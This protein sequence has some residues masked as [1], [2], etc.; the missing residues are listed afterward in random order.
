[1]ENDQEFGRLIRDLRFKAGL[2]L[3]ALADLVGVD[4]SYL[5]KIENGMLPP[6]SENVLSHLA[7]VLKVDRDI[8]FETAGIKTNHNENGNDISADFGKK[9]KK[10]RLHSGMSQA[11]LAAN[12][13]ITPSYLSKMESGAKSPPSKKVVSRLAWA[14][15][16]D[17]NKLLAAANKYKP[18]PNFISMR[19]LTESMKNPLGSL[20]KSNWSR[21]GLAAVMV[22]IIASALWFATPAQA[23]T[24]GISGLPTTGTV[25]QP[26]TFTGLVTTTNN[27]RLPIQSVNLQ[28]NGST[29]I[30]LIGLPIPNV[31][32]GTAS[33]DFTPISG[34]GTFHIVGTTDSNWGY[35]SSTNTYGYGYGYPSGSYGYGYGSGYGYGYGYGTN[36]GP[37]TL[38]YTITWTPGNLSTGPNT[39]NLVV[40]GNGGSSAFTSNAPAP[41]NLSVQSTGSNYGGGGGNGVG[42][43]PPGLTISEDA[44]GR[45]F[46]L[47]G[48]I[49]GQ[50]IFTQPVTA[51]SADNNVH[52][53]I[54]AG[55][56]GLTKD[57]LPLS[58]IT[59]A[60][61]A[62]SP[63]AP[64]GGNVIGLT[65][66]LGPNGATFAPPITLTFNYDPTKLAAG[67]N[68][69]SLVL[70]YYDTVAAQWVNLTNIVVDTVNHTVSA[71]S[72]H[73]TPFAVIS[74]APAA[75][76]TTPVVTGTTP[77]TT[78]PATTTP[79]S[80]TPATTTPAV[81]STAPASTTPAVT[82][83]IPAVTSPAPT[84]V[85]SGSSNTWW[86]V[87]VVIAAI[88]VVIAVIMVVMRRNKKPEIKK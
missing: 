54:N 20:M 86:I 41:I 26:V 85:S 72:A 42:A 29:P 52:A 18:G 55:V 11:E 88:V 80:T 4:S 53:K 49:N 15:K 7:D 40:Y 44:S 8:L 34:G 56:V 76:S 28:I 47:G 17:E 82:A 50:G 13:G 9:L 19:R 24:I 6:P 77:A 78:T 32:N 57:G 71:D 5:S 60:P 68:A 16:T 79:A 45:T 64:T 38:T 83:T 21:A 81:T 69:S 74:R 35:V 22:I 33:Q 48:V 25:G 39:V 30:T 23:L 67:V 46:R 70:A 73:F 10:L 1:M 59:M 27:D 14:L 65:Y 12:A 58:Q 37:T 31:P 43:N 61:L 66:D 2:T 3:K 36:V 75:A 51:D 63:A 62:A 87:I 84:P